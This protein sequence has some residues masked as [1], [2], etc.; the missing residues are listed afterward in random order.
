[1]KRSTVCPRGRARTNNRFL[2]RALS[3]V[4][5]VLL[6]SL[7]ICPVLRNARIDS[8]RTENLHRL[9]LQRGTG[10][11]TVVATPALLPHGAHLVGPTPNGVRLQ[12]A[13]ALTPRDPRGLAV[14]AQAISTPTSPEYHHF[15]NPE[16]IARRYGPTPSSIASVSRELHQLGVGPGTLSKNH[17]LLSVNA[18]TRQLDHLFTTTLLSVRL[19]GGQIGHTL[20]RA[21]T[22][23]HLLGDQITAVIG[24]T[25]TASAHAMLVP[26][27]STNLVTAKAATFPSKLVAHSTAPV[28]CAAAQSVTQGASGWTD[29]Q[30]ASAYGITPLYNAGDLGQGESI[31][32]LELEPFATSDVATF[33]RCY[34]GVSH[35]NQVHRIKVNGFNLVGTGSG[36]AAL[37]I[38]TLSAIAPRAMIDVYEAPNTT[39]GTLDAYDEI[40]SED[41]VAYATTSWGE[42]EQML[43]L[44]SPGARQIEN[45]IFEEAAA[46]GQTFLAAAGDSGS[47]DC[48]TTPFGS[49]RPVAPYLSVDDPASQPY[50]LGVGGSWLRSDIQPL[51]PNAEIAWNDGVG[52]GASGGGLSSNWGSPS[53]QSGSGIV[54]VSSNANRQ[55]PDVVASADSQAGVTVFSRSFGQSGWTTIGGTS[56]AAPI[57]AATLAEIAASG[58]AGTSCA[59]LPLGRNGVQLGFAPPLLY[60]AAANAFTTNFHP[61]Y[62]GTNDMF[63]LGYGYNTNGGYNMVGGLGSPVVTNAGG[64]PGLAATVCNEANIQAGLAVTRPVPAMITPN[65]GPVA[66]GTTVT[67]T[68]ASPIVSGARVSVTLDGREAT[69]ISASGSQILIVTPAAS[70]SAGAPPLS[71]TGLAA[72]SVTESTASASATS[73]PS[74]AAEFAYTDTLGNDALPAVA[75]INPAAS[76]LTGGVTVRIYGSGFVVGTT[77]LVTI[78]GRRASNVVVASATLL[79]AKVPRRTSVTRCARGG[80]FAASAICQTSV[81]VTTSIGSSAVAPIKPVFRG[82]LHYNALGVVLVPPSREIAPAVTEFDYLPTPV[83]TRIDPSSVSPSGGLL[84][85]YGSGFSLSE[86]NWVNYGAANSL[87]SQLIRLTFVA[88][89]K[90]VVRVP[91]ERATSGGVL[92]GGLSVSTAAGV[93]PPFTVV[94]AK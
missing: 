45:F 78:G 11:S 48:A 9:T 35:A 2:I 73:L 4:F 51:V 19:P 10:R 89:T 13:L 33:D 62:F 39:I 59:G 41:R 94:I 88:S 57:W 36:E 91:A 58:S 15:L 74:T 80:G 65:S 47:D 55:V 43:D 32:V 83:V 81:V 64:L 6:G 30:I 22:L 53:W 5:V 25:Q 92:P 93:S 71:A 17:L 8:R 44:S 1:M 28:A 52:G 3:S 56:A 87:S 68:L 76:S 90:I 20:A 7:V 69:V 60:E 38:E 79:T 61:I 86:L 24:L 21:A 18:T 75:G 23:P 29:N 26:S 70:V 66:G 77:P 72:L 63:S 42:C 12:I 14:I 85:I 34:F 40:V 27:V 82:H 54:G 46:Q 37:D 84:T 31:A 16:L 49:S 67:I 50:V